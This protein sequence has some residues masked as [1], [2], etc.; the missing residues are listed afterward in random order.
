MTQSL[1][2]SEEGHRAILEAF[3]KPDSSHDMLKISRSATYI[4]GNG[5]LRAGEF[6]DLAVDRVEERIAGYGDVIQA[7]CPCSPSFFDPGTSPQKEICSTVRG[8]S[9]AS[10]ISPS[11]LHLFS[12]Q[13]F[14]TL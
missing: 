9:Q 10:L 4:P 8:S 14:P 12:Y 11:P 5:S 7:Q 3:R 6:S 13:S 1:G 2:V